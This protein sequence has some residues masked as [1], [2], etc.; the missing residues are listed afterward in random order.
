[1]RT[2]VA[3]GSKM[4]GT[5]G[6]AEMVG[7]A[8]GRHGIEATVLP[9]AAVDTLEGYDAVIVGGAL[10]AAR[11]HRH[12]RRFVKRHRRDLSTRPVWLFSSGPIGDDAQKDDIPPVRGVAKLMRT[13]SARGHATFGGRLTTDPPGAMARAMAKTMAGDW[14][15]PAPV[16][17]WVASIA[18]ELRDTARARATL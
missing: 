18:A 16:D 12:A 1:M 7:E 15:D 17:R 8:L 11:W 3:Y 4:G 9:A 10:Y 6:L 5:A 14:R 2:L 13:V